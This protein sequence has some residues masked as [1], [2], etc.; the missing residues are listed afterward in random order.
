MKKLSEPSAQIPFGIAKKILFFEDVDSTNTTAKELART[1]VEEGTVIIARTQKQGR[2]RF[3]RTW[4]SPEGGV[5]LSVILRPK[6][7]VEK[8]SLLPL[9]AALA[10]SH[11]IKRYGPPATIKWPNDVLVN[12]K[13]IAGILLESEAEGSKVSYVVVGIGVNL[14]IDFTQFSSQIRPRSTSL[15]KEMK[16]SV[17]Y[18]EFLKQF[19]QQFD[20]YYQMFLHEE[21]DRIIKEWKQF[22][23]TLGKTIQIT[24]SEET[25]Q[26]V[27]E[28]I[29]Q[30]GFL[31]V[32]TTDGSIKKVTSG[33]CVYLNEL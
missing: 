17:D 10:V 6:I 13:K 33:D 29:D 2:G 31:L 28:D 24:T 3:D 7:V 30:S 18:Q 25:L 32:K 8:T 16:S 14:N 5:Y 23:D 20:H 4:E 27:A 15:K 26:G 9:I 12:G 19:F 22:S 11:T 21:F 1:G